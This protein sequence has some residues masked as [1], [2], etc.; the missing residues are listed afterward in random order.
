MRYKG[1]INVGKSAK[2]SFLW[3]LVGFVL[4]LSSCSSSDRAES[5][6]YDEAGSDYADFATED[7]SE[8]A[9]E[10]AMADFDDS[11]VEP[12]TQAQN[13][14]AQGEIEPPEAF[15]GESLEEEAV[16]TDE[17][18]LTTNRKIVFSG[19]VFLEVEDVLAAGDK[20]EALA[21]EQG[22][23]VSNE[24]VADTSQQES[25][26]VVR[27]PPDNFD[28]T[29]SGLSKLGSVR[30][31]S[32]NAADVTDRVVDLESQISTT[33]ASV[34]RLRALIARADNLQEISQLEQQ[35]LQRETSLES[36][37]GQLKTIESQ[38]SLSTINVRLSNAF[39]RPAVEVNQT[40]YIDHDKGTS[41]NGRTSL[42][43][44]EGDDV[45]ICY[46]IINTGSS[47]FSS[48]T[49]KDTVLE[50]ETKDLIVVDGDL[51]KE[52]PAGQSIILAHETKADRTIRTRT[53]VEVT[54]VSDEGDELEVQPVA[55]T[56]NMVIN[57]TD[58]GD[59]P[60]FGDGLEGS[61][62]FIKSLG[63]LVVLLAGV[64]LPLLIIIVPLAWLFVRYVRPRFKAKAKKR[65][66]KKA[67]RMAYYAQAQP[68]VNVP[69][70]SNPKV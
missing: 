12:A 28:N 66:E 38:L 52:L 32:K 33:A 34:E 50:I 17:S 16:D 37:R 14:S 27:V 43:V 57:T 25:V 35:L 47:S 41:C 59:V 5:A 56:T 4:V 64:L 48:V 18:D 9:T 53:R 6:S 51:S 49:V 1:V 22:G 69:E 62:N 39:G 23:Y 55:N 20:V 13:R 30:S 67:E 44:D 19:D 46:E 61:W 60:G 29:L 58:N 54:A 3:V 63:S 68:Q 45:T 21:K 31:Q 15:D 10:D 70:Q 2:T 8:E 65:A 11:N 36:L 40:A 42:R 7:A 26:L 24:Q